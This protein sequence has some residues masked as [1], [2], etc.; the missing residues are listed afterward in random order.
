[1]IRHGADEHPRT[2]RRHAAARRVRDLL[3]A[4]IVH[5]EFPAGTLPGEPELMLA[6]STSRQVIRD[7]L[8]LLRDEGLVRR[9]QGAGTLSTASKVRHNF[10]FL[11]GPD[12]ADSAVRHRVLAVN[13]EPAAPQVAQR[14][15][16]DTGAGCGVIDLLTT[17]DDEPF[18]ACTTYVPATFLPVVSQMDARM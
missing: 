17:L 10:G 2:G 12:G 4:A 16:I 1:M 13:E 11:H 6:F 18:Y 8:E 9:A 14:L 7:A 3:R 5:D 15:G